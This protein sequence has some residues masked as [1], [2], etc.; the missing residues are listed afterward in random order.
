MSRIGVA[1]A[2]V[3]FGAQSVA[4]RSSEHRDRTYTLLAA[5]RD[6]V[7]RRGDRV[8]IRTIDDS[9]SWTW[10]Q[11]AG[12]AVSFA[13]GLFALGLR[14][15]DRIALM[16]DNRPEFYVADLGAVHLA[17][18]PF[19]I[20]PTA[21]VDQIRHML[22]DSGARV[23]V[24]EARHREAVHQAVI[25][26]SVELVIAV[27]ESGAE[28]PV[29]AEP[30]G[31]GGEDHAYADVLRR[32]SQTDADLDRI[33]DDVDA[34]TQLTIIYTS[35]T[36]GAP[37]GVELTHRNALAAIAAS[38]ARIPF[39]AE[40]RVISWLPPAHIAERIAHYYLPIAYGIEVTCFPDQKRIMEA[41]AAVQPTWFFAVPRIWEKLKAGI[42]AMFDADEDPAR[43]DA[44]QLCLRKVRLEQNESPVPEELA[45]AAAA[46]D[47]DHFA[48]LRAALGFGALVV[49]NVGSAPVPRD[50]LE[51]FHAI[52][53]ELSEIWGMSETCGA[54]CANPYDRVKIGTVGPP[55]PG[56]EVKLAPDG[57]LL[58]RS[59]VVMRGYRNMPDVSAETV[60]DGW[61]HTGDL[62]EIRADGYVR[63]IDR[64][65]DL[66]INSA[67]KNMSPAFIESQLKSASPL[68]AQ[69]CCVGDGRPYNVALIALDPDM[70]RRWAADHELSVSGVAELATQPALLA[71]I[72]AA[73]ARAN[74]TLSRPEQL[75]KFRVIAR[76]W[77][78]TGGE[79]T[80]SM[81][82]RRAA[83]LGRHA[84]DIDELY[85]N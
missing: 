60:V 23:L 28:G 1:A 45:A 33:T 30:D 61:L 81:K 34:D 21:P 39:P 11:L 52:G 74:T 25:G 20:Y 77:T 19:S 83:V 50:V 80:P 9:V 24:T 29:G 16:I 53:I 66:I 17:A 63:V 62:G 3:D 14:P 36:T 71:E 58:I 68:I 10:Q 47:R 46:A 56:V 48:A 31:P 72:A 26:T 12:H 44:L 38:E 8:A 54:G 43:R 67:G 69:V 41:V 32:G 13:K 73:V 70:A 27:P 15:G 55:A 2:E 85:R 6:T 82:L 7:R 37:K 40:S 79:L 76:E 49:A 59:D 18:I 84:G 75:K 22:I 65:K 4:E 42:E 64:K 5:L 51:F 57:E 35:G 78:I